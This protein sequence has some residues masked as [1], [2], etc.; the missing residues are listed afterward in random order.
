LP[1]LPA[2]T[3][4]APPSEPALTEALTATPLPEPTPTFPPEIVATMPEQIAGVWCLK[5]FIGQGGLVNVKGKNL[6]PSEP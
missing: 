5:N 4:I 3:T 6:M 2:P 1:T